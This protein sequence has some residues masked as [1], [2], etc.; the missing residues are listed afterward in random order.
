MRM[1]S[2]LSYGVFI[3]P[4]RGRVNSLRSFPAPHR[5]PAFFTH[6]QNGILGNL[7]GKLIDILIREPNQE[8]SIYDVENAVGLVVI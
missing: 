6:C 3:P 5:R 7:R 2:E 4:N 1:I 8:R